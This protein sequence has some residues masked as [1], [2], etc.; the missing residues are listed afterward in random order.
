MTTAWWLLAALVAALALTV[1]AGCEPSA[2][3]RRRY[4]HALCFTLA[5]AY[6]VTLLH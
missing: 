6:A 5:A 3:L 4:R 1:C 2:R